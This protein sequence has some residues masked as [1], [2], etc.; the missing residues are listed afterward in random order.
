MTPTPMDKL[1]FVSSLVLTL[2][3]AGIVIESL[4]MPRLDHLAINPFTAPGLVPGFIGVLLTCCGL[5]IFIRSL[6]RGGW[7]IEIN[8]LK[9]ASWTRSGALK[10]SG[11]TLALTLIYAL[12]LFPLIP[13]WIAT[14]VFVFAF[15]MTAETMAFGGWPKP[16]AILTGLVLAILAG[17]VIGYVF[18]ELF[19]V[20]LPGG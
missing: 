13:F 16:K 10:R 14:S 1:D 7:R 17:L 11:A 9:N 6:K 4:R 19:F 2:F 18:Q 5:A 12:V 20:R 15:I 8:A 3:G